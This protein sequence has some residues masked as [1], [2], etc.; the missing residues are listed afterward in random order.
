M[1]TTCPA[2]L[3]RFDLIC[4][5]IFRDDNKIWTSSLCNF[6]YFPAASF[7]FGPNTL[8]KTLFSNT[9]CLR[10]TLKVRLTLHLYAKRVIIKVTKAIHT[11]ALTTQRKIWVL[12]VSLHFF[13]FVVWYKLSRLIPPPLPRLVI[14]VNLR[15]TCSWSR[16]NGRRDARSSGV[17]S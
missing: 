7:L 1:R 15:V 12:S 13:K 3:I 4:L 8:L 5:M 6:L 11:V 14:Y 2:H 17:T 9:R 16:L 10:S